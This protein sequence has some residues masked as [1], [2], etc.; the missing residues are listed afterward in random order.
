M[1]G[2]EVSKLTGLHQ[3]TI[4]KIVRINKQVN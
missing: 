1:K 2:V 3:N 4:S